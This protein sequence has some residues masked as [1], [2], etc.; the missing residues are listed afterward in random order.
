[1][2]NIKSCFNCGSPTNVIPFL[3]SYF[4]V[5]CTKCE[6]SDVEFYDTAETAVEAWNKKTIKPVLV[7]PDKEYG[8][9]Y[10]CPHCKT[11]QYVCKGVKQCLACRQM[12]DFRKSDK[13]T[14]K[15]QWP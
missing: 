13:Y 3:G 15:V 1:M 6:L 12:I 7:K 4:K 5:H 11:V 14:G 8:W 10:A 9:I 2:E